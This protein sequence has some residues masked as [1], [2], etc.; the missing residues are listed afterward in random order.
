LARGS[1]FE[2]NDI[3]QGHLFRAHDASTMHGDGKTYNQV[4]I[5]VRH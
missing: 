2:V 1:A 5:E 3:I 4:D